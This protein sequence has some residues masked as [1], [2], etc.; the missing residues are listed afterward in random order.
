MNEASDRFYKKDHWMKKN[1]ALSRLRFWL[2][3]VSRFANAVAKGRNYDLL[4]LG[5]GPVKNVHT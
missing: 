2:E 1:L 3:K 4:Y 5:Y